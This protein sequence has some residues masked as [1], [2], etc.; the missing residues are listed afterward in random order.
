MVGTHHRVVNDPLPIATLAKCFA[1]CPLQIECDPIG[2][3]DPALWG[4]NYSVLTRDM[5]TLNPDDVSPLAPLCALPVFARS[6][7]R[8]HV[9]CVQ[10]QNK[11]G[12]R[13]TKVGQ[14]N[15][16][17]APPN[18]NFQLCPGYPFSPGA[19]PSDHKLPY[20]GQHCRRQR[21][22]LGRLTISLVRD[23]QP[24]PGIQ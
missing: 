2:V 15:G 14:S 12:V 9:E 17:A 4:Q 16:L 8:Y 21:S 1:T 11:L 18:C 5:A 13:I 22:F 7:K 3:I 10:N 19:L 6:L 23:F 20:R 24:R